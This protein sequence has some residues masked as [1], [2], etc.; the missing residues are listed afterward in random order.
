MM[1][2]EPEC[3]FRTRQRWVS[4]ALIG[5]V[6]FC[7]PWTFSGA[8]VFIAIAAL[9][10]AVTL[11][12]TPSGWRWLA[13]VF[14]AGFAILLVGFCATFF[15]TLLFSPVEPP[16]FGSARE[17]KWVFLLLCIPLIGAVLE[18]DWRKAGR[19]LWVRAAVAAFVGVVLT[20][21]AVGT[22][23]FTT[24][25]LTRV[26]VDVSSYPRAHGFFSNPIPF[27]HVAGAGFFFLIPFAMMI[28]KRCD[29]R[30]LSATTIALF[31]ALLILAWAVF[32]SVSRGSVGALLA[33]FLISVVFGLRGRPGV[34]MILVVTM[35]LVSAVVLTASPSAWD[36]LVVNFDSETWGKNPRY[37]M[38]RANWEMVSDYPW[39]IGYGNNL[40]I[41][42][43]YF[44]E[45]GLPAEKMVKHAHQEFLEVLVGTGWI[46][47]F[48]FSAL[49][50]WVT[51]RGLRVYTWL[52]RR[53]A[54]GLAAL[55]LGAVLSNIYLHGCA[56]TDQ[57]DS[58]SRIILV[59]ASGLIL[60]LDSGRRLIERGDVEGRCEGLRLWAR[61]FSARLR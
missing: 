9:S 31:V 8:N 3:L 2:D 41:R 44:E 46:G 23:Q 51:W 53:N 38:W 33:T 29:R 34:A 7:L 40:S 43:E 59:L 14:G 45:L 19:L 26:D 57:I 37:A 12:E 4:A 50:A 36:R 54:H 58:P 15:L 35:G 60:T 18:H 47:F 13:H 42:E 56:M 5:A 61:G 10:G 21:V 39:G 17:I 1:A 11:F 22:V 48:F 27:A 28:G 32:A 24:G 52:C 6:I 30:F 49:V 25:Q 55:A 16:D 20:V